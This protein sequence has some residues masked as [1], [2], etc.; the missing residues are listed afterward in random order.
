M[1]FKLKFSDRSDAIIEADN[2]SQLA[3]ILYNRYN[4]NKR[5]NVCDERFVIGSICPWP[6]AE[7]EFE[8][9][10]VSSGSNCPILSDFFDEE[11][12][13]STNYNDEDFELLPDGLCLMFLNNEES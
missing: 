13:C 2:V 3:E 8:W 10:N 11:N 6:G 1:Q 5:I 4:I 12:S 7:F 9:R